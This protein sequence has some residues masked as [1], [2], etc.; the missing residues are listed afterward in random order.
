MDTCNGDGQPWHSLEFS[1]S[2]HWLEFLR[3]N[4]FGLLSFEKEKRNS[5]KASCVTEEGSEMFILKADVLFQIISFSSKWR[6]HRGVSYIVALLTV[7][8]ALSTFNYFIN[9]SYLQPNMEIICRLSI[10]MMN[11][12]EKQSSLS[13]P[14]V[15]LPLPWEQIGLSGQ[16]RKLRRWRPEDHAC[17]LGYFAKGHS[18]QNA[19]TFQ[20]VHLWFISL[21]KKQMLPK[22]PKCSI[23]KSHQNSPS[24]VKVKNTS[25]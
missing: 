6:Q 12:K 20:R 7:L 3:P 19:H 17:K 18:T 2:L 11:T 25:A 4:L 16:W 22:T 13:V 23:R 8:T 10:F 15:L 9:F 5:I 21:T 24:F 14:K 1:L